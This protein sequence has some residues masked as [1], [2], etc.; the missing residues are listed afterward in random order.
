[1]R[2][3]TFK[4]LRV[5]GGARNDNATLGKQYMESTWSYL[6]KFGASIYIR[7]EELSNNHRVHKYLQ[8]KHQIVINIEK[9]LFLS[10]KKC[11]DVI[12]R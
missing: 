12:K 6:N 3:C 1:M 2:Q 5:S 9:T 8:R 10:R 7:K 4:L 11:K